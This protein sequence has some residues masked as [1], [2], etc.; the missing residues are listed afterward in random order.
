MASSGTYNDRTFNLAAQGHRQPGSAFKT[1]AYLAAIASKKSTTS[2]LLL[3]APVKIQLARNETWQPQN[4]DQSFRGRVTL[5]E[6]F[7][8]S[9][10]VPTVRLAQDVGIPEP[11]RV[12]QQGLVE[13]RNVGRGRYTARSGDADPE[14]RRRVHHQRGMGGDRRRR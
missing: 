10:N 6:A 3:D 2:S 11:E 5:R 1:F 7:E 9:L 14:R 12:M 4:Y 8:R 13:E